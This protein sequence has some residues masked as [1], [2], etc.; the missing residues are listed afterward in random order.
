MFYWDQYHHRTRT[1][2]I[3]F[4]SPQFVSALCCQNNVEVLLFICNVTTTIHKPV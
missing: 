1:M 4:D 2:C 3:V